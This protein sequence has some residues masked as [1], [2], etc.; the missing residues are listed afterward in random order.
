LIKD[1]PVLQERCRPS[2]IK[3]LSRSNNTDS[4]MP[5]IRRKFS[6]VPMM[7]HDLGMPVAD[8]RKLADHGPEAADLLARRMVELDLNS[9]ELAATAPGTLQD[10]Q[11][12]CTLCESHRKCARDLGR[13]P[14]DKASEDY[15]LN[16][17]MLKL[18]DSMPW[19]SRS[20]W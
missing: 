6:V 8:L 1:D 2:R 12:L 18:L 16:V 9:D 14:A 15:C 17:A 10:L 19:K 4:M 3:R 7:A 20:E 13:D 5:L 11:R